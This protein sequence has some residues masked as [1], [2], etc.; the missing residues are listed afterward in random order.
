MKGGAKTP[1][2][3]SRFERKQPGGKPKKYPDKF[4]NYAE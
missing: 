1:R 4:T 3:L 2:L